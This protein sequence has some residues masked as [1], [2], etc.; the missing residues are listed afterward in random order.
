MDFVLIGA[1]LALVFIS[2][3]QLALVLHVRNTIIDAAASGA[4]YGALADRSPE[5]G[6][7][8]ARELIDSALSPEFSRNITVSQSENAGLPVLKITVRAP[9]PIIGLIGPARILEVSGHG[10]IQP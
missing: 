8:R 10:A 3:V 1:L 4:R 9:L 2:V 5:E 6:A 7:D